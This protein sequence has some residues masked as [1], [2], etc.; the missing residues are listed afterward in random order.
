MTKKAHVKAGRPAATGG[1][2]A[3]GL[4]ILAPV[5]ESDEQ[6]R[7]RRALTSKAEHEGPGVLKVLRLADV[8]VLSGGR[9]RPLPILA[10]GDAT[11]LYERVHLGRVAVLRLGR[12]FVRRDPST[13]PVRDRNVITV[14]RYVRYK[15]YSG[16]IRTDADVAGHLVA[17]KQYRE[18]LQ[19]DGLDDAR[20]L[21]LH[22]FNCPRDWAA[23]DGDDEKRRFLVEHGGT[24]QYR[25]D[26]DGAVWV[27]PKGQAAKHGTLEL[28]VAGYA[29]QRGFHW[30]VNVTSSPVRIFTPD[31][32]WQIK[33]P[34]GAKRGTGSYLNVYPNGHIRRSRSASACR[35]IWP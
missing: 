2:T 14:E 13:K 5:I 26:C 20:I 18:I 17:F 8:S 29:V 6:E 35:Q 31:A 32:V 30:D 4:I 34:H 24:A 3:D 7:L 27:K 11:W 25:R 10:P 1:G 28:W 33:P 12:A 22:I 15:A 19:C 23:L 21:P 9:P 16:L